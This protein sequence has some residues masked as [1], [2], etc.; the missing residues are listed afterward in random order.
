MK[1]L[2]PDTE[3]PAHVAEHPMVV[4]TSANTIV[5][6][7]SGPHAVVLAK[8]LARYDATRAGSDPVAGY[9]AEVWHHAMIS[10]LT[11]T[12]HLRYPVADTVDVDVSLVDLTLRSPKLHAVGGG[13]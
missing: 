8:I 2:A 1:H 6:E 13:R 3:A 10:L 5:M 9:T 12:A 11:Q 4:R 7:L